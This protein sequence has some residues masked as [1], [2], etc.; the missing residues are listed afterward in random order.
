MLF[1]NNLSK[2][3]NHFSFMNKKSASNRLSNLHDKTHNR[4]NQ[5]SFN[6]REIEKVWQKKWEENK[7]YYA[8]D[9][10][11]KKKFYQL[12][13][14]PYPSG[15]GLHVGHVRSWTGMDAY[16]RKKRMEGYNVLYPIGWD[17]FGLPTEN[18]AIKMGVH[19]SIITSKNIE[20]FKRQIK[21]LGISFDWSREI[22]TSDPMYYKW[23]Q[24]IFLKLYEHGLAYQ[25]ESYVNWCPYCKTNL[26][27]EEV[28]ANG[29]HERCGN[30]TEK[31]LQKQWLLRITKYAERLIN[32]LEKVNF[33]PSIRD[34]Q[35]NWIGRKSG[36]EIVFQLK[37]KSDKI[38]VFTTRPDT[39]FGVTFMVVSPEYAEKYLVN[40]ITEDN[41]N[42]VIEYIS[43]SLQKTLIERD[44]IKKEKTGVFTGI[45]AINPA[46]DIEVPIY[47]AD[48][49]LSDYGTGAV[50]GV[51]AHDE[52]DFAFAKKHSIEIIEVVDGAKEKDSAFSG[53][54][55]L[56]NS[57]DW[58]GIK[59]PENL[60]KIISDIEKQGW[61]KAEA[62]YHLHDWVFS[63]QHYWGEPIPIIH[64]SDC[65]AV[66]VSEKDLP[67]EL[68]YLEKYKPSGTGESPLADATEWLN[69]AC[70]RC[71]KQARRETDTM[72]NWA[73]SN[74]Y[75]IRYTD[76]SN[77]KEIA[78]KDKMKHWLPVDF[79][80]GGVEHITLHLLYSRFIYKF[81]YDIG[82]VPTDEPY[83][84]RRSHGIVLGPD[85]RKM[86]KSY[87][88]VINPDEIVEKFGADT[89]RLYEMFIGPFENTV[90]WSYESLEG[91]SRFLGK[92]WRAFNTKVEEKTSNILSIKLNQTIKKVDT[93]VEELKYNT[94]VASLMELLN[95]WDDEESLSHDDA[96]KLCCLIAPFSPHLAEEVWVNVLGEK[97]SV[98]QAPWPKHDPKLVIEQTITIPIQVNG[99]LR[100]TI[101]VGREKADDKKTILEL[102]KSDEKVK[103]WIERKEIKKEIYIE[104]KLVN[105]VV[106]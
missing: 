40:L 56:I 70:P 46:S 100:S 47:V 69:V 4:S 96:K 34:Q 7:L 1:V 31:R 81:L 89:I 24:W 42:E 22:N 5:T 8:S 52:R 37:G 41:K 10:S 55:K 25:S 57:G 53:S 23:T 36:A 15:A 59:V 88:N 68:P 86:S 102:A 12:I 43:K 75:Y 85:G 2:E 19:P 71:G 95:V 18:Y 60:S 103:K 14:F 93:D 26:A 58:N 67:V 50:M 87:G 65:G 94:I 33:S 21:S 78:A 17:A 11:D 16:S 61:G 9:A 51:P 99:K 84:K 27:D 13:E 62:T 3:Y 105:F 101:E 106:N 79:Y 38:K 90:A 82:V 73:G 64:C 77:N 28:L 32:D 44:N 72:P 92:L 91:C 80:Q 29:T 20:N 45:Y 97:F 30:L 6:H 39:I 74:W 83:K 35:I 104:G 48:Y 49:V 63:R 98:H 66:A 76:P 54:G